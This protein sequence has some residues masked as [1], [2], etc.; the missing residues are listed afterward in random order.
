MVVIALIAY[1]NDS[2]SDIRE[3]EIS[4]T[5]QI[6]GPVTRHI[7]NPGFQRETDALQ[8][9]RDIDFEYGIL[10]IEQLEIGNLP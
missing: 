7:V 8:P 1:M 5:C 6:P 10:V 9:V 3:I 2:G 4:L